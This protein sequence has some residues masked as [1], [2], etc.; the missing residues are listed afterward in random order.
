MGEVGEREKQAVIL[1]FINL[2]L[3]CLITESGIDRAR[4]RRCL[5]HLLPSG[6]HRVQAR[7]RR[8]GAG[9][10]RAATAAAPPEDGL[11][12][13]A[14]EMLAAAAF[15]LPGRRTATRQTPDVTLSSPEASG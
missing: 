10:G 11:V 14:V 2:G 12:S 3:L 1:Q 5:L 15:F 7:R 6:N 4:H 13:S 8:G 9:G